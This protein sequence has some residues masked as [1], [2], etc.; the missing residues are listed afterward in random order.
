MAVPAIYDRLLGIQ[1]MLVGVHQASDPL[2]SNS[3][4]VEREAFI[5]GFLREVLPSIYRFGTGDVVDLQGNKSGQLDVVVEYPFAPSLPITQSTPRLYLAEG[6]AAVIEVKSDV[7]TQW[8]EVL[9]TAKK[10]EPIRQ[11]QSGHRSTVGDV[12][13]NQLPLFV[14]GYTGW[15][16]LNTVTEHLA[17]SPNMAAILVIDS[18]LFASKGE[19]GGNTV[20]GSS[21]AL[22]GLVTCIYRA[23]SHLQATQ[24]DPFR[25]AL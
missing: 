20:E 12:P 16:T 7:A 4:G 10:L 22:W 15:K 19:Y 2:S 6:V 25:Y 11:D 17:D 21:W 13:P 9:Y 23:I 8:K 14:V 3:K 24:T 5:N 18:G 1:Q